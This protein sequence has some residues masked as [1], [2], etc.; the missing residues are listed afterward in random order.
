MN[1]CD[2]GCGQEATHKFKNGKW[3]CAKHSSLCPNIKKK[4][5]QK[6]KGRTPWN[7]N[8][9][10]CFSDKT[11]NIWKQQR[12]GK[13]KSKEHK[14]KISNSKLGIPSVNKGKKYTKE[15][16]KNRTY[17]KGEEH[18]QWK[19]GYIDPLYDTYNDQI[20]FCEKTRRYFDDKNILEVKCRY[21]GKWYIP[22]KSEVVSRIT[23][24]NKGFGGCNFYCSEQCKQECPIYHQV[25]YSK[26]YK[27]MMSREVQPEL[28]QMRFEID[29][30]TCQKCGKH[31]DELDVGLHCH[32]K[33]GIRWE[34]LES[35]DVDKVITLCK[36]CHALVHQ[37]KDCGYNDMK[38][39][40]EFKNDSIFVS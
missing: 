18:P 36:K 2:Y 33:E 24:I 25:K 17:L 20:N 34:P 28:R 39:N 11:K 26:D 15:E 30:Y 13:Q 8:K 22:K 6:L 35:A 9:K 1:I 37:Q 32:H 40:K 27:P 14:E 19:G 29:N 38:C 23:A 16:L 5:S 31:Q 10:D 7:K 3:C 12:K 21:C 4:Q